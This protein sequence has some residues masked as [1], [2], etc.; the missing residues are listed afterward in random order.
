MSKR[1]EIL[2]ASLVK[3]EKQFDDKLQNHFQTVKQANGQPLNDKRNE[4]ATLNKWERQNDS[5]I[6]LKESIQKTKDAI[7]REEGKILNVNHA[8]ESIPQEILT[9]VESGELV[10]WRK[11]PNY[12]F[13]KGVDYARIIWDKKKKVVM[14]K[15]LS[16]ISDSEQYKI[17]ATTYNGLNKQLKK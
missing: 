13:V 3:K 6:S 17:F 15:Y 2:K 8:N 16:K 1:L 9:L 4:Q 7:E 14:H 12:F 10:Q 11:H 5:L